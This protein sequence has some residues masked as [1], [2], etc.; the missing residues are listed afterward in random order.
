MLLEVA[1]VHK[2]FGGVEALRGV[3]L[4]IPDGDFVG[5]IGPNGSGKTTLIN[6]LTGFVRVDRGRIRLDEQRVDDLS[7][8]ELARRGI[9]RTF[10]ICKVFRRLTVLENLEIPGL[11][12]RGSVREEVTSRARRQ[13]A[14]LNLDRHA[15][16][17][18]AELSGGQQKLVEFGMVMMLDPRVILL[19]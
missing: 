1:G 6:C 3:S 9:G 19:D 14:S 10:Q 8:F 16:A 5:L 18:A 2:A 7:A 13:L 17:R 12:R 11:S 4:A 15:S